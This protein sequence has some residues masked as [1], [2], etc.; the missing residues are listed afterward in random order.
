[1]KTRNSSGK[2]RFVTA[3]HATATAVM[4]AGLVMGA[5][6]A[7]IAQAT[8][9]QVRV[10]G[11]QRI[12]PAT[13]MSYIDV[14]AG[15]PFDPA[16]LDRALKSL[17]ATGLF[18]D[19]SLYQEGNDLIVV[20]VENPIVNDINF[21]GNDKLK[22]DVLLSE[23]QIR[24]RTVFTRTRVQSDVERLQEVYRLSGRFSAS[25]EPKIIKLDQNRVNLVF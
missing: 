16:R 4:L 7:A 15:D 18:A 14:Q 17:Y 1:M 22:D 12:E 6:S 10:E 11:S 13:V 2:G 24:P 3:L 8:I 23:I 20:V 9:K 19:V 25:I 21:E 5:S